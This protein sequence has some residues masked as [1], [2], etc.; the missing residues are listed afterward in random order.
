MKNVVS[1]H[2]QIQNMEN[3]S[4]IAEII[5]K[6]RIRGAAISVCLYQAPIGINNV[7]QIKCIKNQDYYNTF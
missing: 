7:K 3:S 2:T 1:P 4:Y 6:Y 5:N